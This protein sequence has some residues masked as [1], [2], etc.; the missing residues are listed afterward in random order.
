MH[1]HVHALFV[2]TLTT[3]CLGARL[4]WL[5]SFFPGCYGGGE[6]ECANLFL[7][8]THHTGL[9]RHLP[10]TM[11]VACFLLSIKM[12]CEALVLM[13]SMMQIYLC[14]GAFGALSALGVMVSDWILVYWIGMEM[15]DMV[16]FFDYMVTVNARCRDILGW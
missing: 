8:C 15:M 12:L 11:L 14:C 6:H 4:A 13:C 16:A 1:F 5:A 7:G 9:G 10:L 2:G 3:L